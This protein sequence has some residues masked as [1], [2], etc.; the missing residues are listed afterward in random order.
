VDATRLEGHC[1]DAA[2]NELAN[3]VDALMSQVASGGHSIRMVPSFERYDRERLAGAMDA[4]RYPFA[5]ERELT[6]AWGRIDAALG[7]A[8]RVPRLVGSHTEPAVRRAATPASAALARV[9]HERSP[10]G[11]ARTDFA[12]C[13]PPGS[14]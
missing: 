14:Y 4:G 8:D 10:C 5:S 12:P 3:E 6:D 9:P 7:R 2:E 13:S 11:T 1:N